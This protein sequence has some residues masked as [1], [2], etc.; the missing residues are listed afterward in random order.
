MDKNL[1]APKITVFM[2]CYNSEKFISQ[3]IRSILNQTF[4]DFELLIVNDGSTD[5]SVNII[6]SFKDERIKL[7]HN[8]TN[9][10][11]VHTRNVA[12][13]EAS[14][15]YIAILD[16]DDESYPNRL[17]LQYDFLQTNLNISLCGGHALVID[18][19]GLE[20]GEKLIVPHS[21]NLNMQMIFG[22]P[23]VNS[24]T[25]F[26]SSILRELKGYREYAPAEDYDFFLR[27]AEKNMVVN[28][29]HFL[30]KYRIHN[31]NIS[32]LKTEEKLNAERKIISDT[33]NR[34]GLQSNDD[35]LNTHFN[36]FTFQYKK[37]S[38]EDYLFLFKTLKINN[39]LN[40]TFPLLEFE[41]LLFNKWYEII[42]RKRAG[43]NTLR[44]YF[45][46]ELF[47]WSFVTFKQLR[48]MFKRSFSASNFPDNI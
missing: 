35:I 47:R 42:Y 41:N 40:K 28:I 3:S 13:T 15:E 12:L 14:G 20:T 6:N 33:H 4:T 22:N 34:L 25:M 9:K 19:N 8:L 11:L 43:K 48:R 36:L 30:V 24:T 1:K 21:D 39:R 5:D 27:I 26:K 46:K 38:F 31:H 7:I 17:Q 45:N 16:S 18:E 29:N 37:N 32:K 10:G 44:L 23:F 2:A